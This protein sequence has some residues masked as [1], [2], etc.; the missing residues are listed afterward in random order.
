MNNLNNAHILVTRPA[1]QA[2]N[3]CRLI[4][5]QGGKAIRFPTLDIQ[6]VLDPGHVQNILANSR[7]IQWL[8][9][10]SANAVNFALKANGGKIP[11]SNSVRFA[12]VGQSTARALADAGV[13]VDLVSDGYSSEALLATPQLQQVNGLRFLIVR[14]EGG[15]EELASVLRGRGAEVGYLNVYKRVVPTVDNSEVLRLLGQRKLDAITITSGEALQNLL[16]MIP[17]PY[18]PMLLAIPIIVVSGRI[19]Q[20]A[21]D[22]GFKQIVAAEYP[23]DIAIMVAVTISLTGK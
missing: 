11:R 7:K 8:I 13:S 1:H 3:L 12:A 18:H 5:I 10:I 14:G 16:I 15:R 2:E 20:M 4:E 23:A 22:L 17:Q 21:G 6:A 19:A 9:F